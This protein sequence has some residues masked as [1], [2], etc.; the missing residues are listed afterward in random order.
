MI[1]LKI[2]NFLK[3]KKTYSR[4]SAKVIIALLFLLPFLY[5]VKDAINMPTST[6][7]II[8]V[9]M[10]FIIIFNT[11][12]IYPPKNN[13]QKIL[14][15]IGLVLIFLIIALFLIFW[16]SVLHMANLIGIESK[17]TYTS[18]GSGLIAI[19]G[20]LFIYQRLEK[21]QKQ[22]D[23][24][25]DQRADDRFNS[26][27]N[28][29]GSSE[30]SARTGAIYALYELAIEEEKYR[31]QIAQIL[32]SHIRSKTNE[33]EYKDTHSERPS[34]EI[35]TTIDLLFKEKGLY[36]QEFARVVEFPKANLSHAYLMGA[37][38]T[39]AWCQG[40]NFEYAQCQRTFFIGAQCQDASFWMAQ[41]KGANFL[42]AQCQDAS[43]WMAQCQEANFRD[44]QCQG[45]GFS[46]TAQL[47]GADFRNAQLQGAGFR[48]AQL[49]E[50]NFVGAECQGADFEGAKFDR[51]H[52]IQIKGEISDKAIKAIE[53]AKPYLD[54][55]W[56]EKMKQIIEENKGKDPE[57]RTYGP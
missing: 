18:I 9:V 37:D 4:S 34:N 14:Q 39:N 57:F 20:L 52:D 19:F 56:Y 41:C 16:I 36:G 51:P 25:I 6:S 48:N 10:I 26:A 7:I 5:L 35:Q 11:V 31:S 50:A 40:V 17:I 30:T 23:I 38:F 49:Q 24:Q 33:T 32:C 21:Q 15:D 13:L 2:K 29:L 28:L 8:A 42:L 47:Q 55:S 27:I 1:D 45:A 22:I 53:D 54:N 43:F 46:N 3:G 12:I 44:A